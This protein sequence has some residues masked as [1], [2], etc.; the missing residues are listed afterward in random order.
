MTPTIIVQARVESRRFPSKMLATLLGQPM[1]LRLLDRL[2]QYFPREQ[3]WLA[4]PATDANKPLLELARRH[5]Y[6]AANPVC[7]SDDVLARYFWLA[8]NSQADPVIRIT[9]DCPLIDGEVIQQALNLYNDDKT[10]DYVALASEW[11]DG[12]D[13]EVIRFSALEKAH[14]EATLPTDREHVTPFL[15]RQP[16]RFKQA[17]LL[18]PFDLSGQR[19]SVDTR[20]DLDFLE[21]VLWM[22]AEYGKSD[23][24][25]WRDVYA[26]LRHHAS[27]IEKQFPGLLL[28]P[29]ARNADY[30][31][32]VA[33]E[34]GDAATGKTWKQARYGIQDHGN[35]PRP[36]LSTER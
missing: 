2:V 22:L 32:Q 21:M 5:G 9:G 12:L 1:V 28:Q 26:V 8:Q 6:Q 17:L 20:Q 24:H 19:W 16:E 10:L 18:C 14:Q 36:D 7:D 29:S 27:Y 35:D 25:T 31:R 13:C 33:R 23:T 3:I 4:T 34:Q 30:M 11:G 15:W